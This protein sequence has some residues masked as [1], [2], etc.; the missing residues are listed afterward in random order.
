[1]ISSQNVH[2]CW[3]L[4]F[5][6]E[7]KAYGLNSLTTSIYIISKEEIAALWWQSSILEESK[8]VVVLSMN[9]SAYFD[10]CVDLQ[11]HGLIEEDLFG[12]LQQTNDGIFGQIDS[13]SRFLISDRE[14][15]MDDLIDIE[16]NFRVVH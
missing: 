10:G 9:I 13:F 14:Q 7:K 3:V 15:L 16:L 8:E 6:G 11:Q 5:E 4:C 2:F 1:M 12:N